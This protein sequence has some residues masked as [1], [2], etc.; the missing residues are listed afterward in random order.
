MEFLFL[1]LAITTILLAIVT[2]VGHG[3]WLSVAAFLRFLFSDNTGVKNERQPTRLFEPT[4]AP[5][6]DL[7]ITERQIITFY[8]HGKLDERT[9][10]QVIRRIRAERASVG[11]PAV[12]ASASVPV[13]P[14]NQ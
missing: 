3:I 8:I 6:D 5:L 10:G 12:K 7:D 1:T 11:T 13:P 2:V 14:R 4:T 9:Y